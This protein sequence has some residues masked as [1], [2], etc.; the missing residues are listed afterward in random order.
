MTGYAGYYDRYGYQGYPVNASRELTESSP[1]QRI[2]EPLEV[3]EIA[4][5]LNLPIS[6]FTDPEK[7][8]ELLAMISAARAE[9][10]RRQNR[11]LVR[12]QY[13]MTLDYWPQCP[14][15]LGTPL[16]SVDLVQYLDANGNTTAL[17]ENTDYKV[18]KDKRP[19]FIT[20]LYNQTWP[21]FTPQPSSSLLVR[22]TTGYLPDALFWS[23]TGAIVKQGMK[24]LISDWW[25]KRLP[26]GE[27]RGAF[28]FPYAVTVCLEHGAV[29]RVR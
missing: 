23:D 25:N 7:N 19:G 11:D 20:P 1:P 21:I 17:V 12:K 28:E 16:V 3:L 6:M 15:E 13:D 5:Y 14:L 4:T 9:A 24:L 22:F 27:G 2:R 26:F 8:A 10:E 29:Q 18:Y